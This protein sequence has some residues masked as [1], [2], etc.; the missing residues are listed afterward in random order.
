MG[1]RVST[2]ATWHSITHTH[3]PAVGAPSSQGACRV[4]RPAA[5][6][7]TI[8][9]VKLCSTEPWMLSAHLMRCAKRSSSG[10]FHFKGR[11]LFSYVPTTHKRVVFRFSL[12]HRLIGPLGR[13]HITHVG[14]RSIRETHASTGFLHA[15]L[16][17][18]VQLKAHDACR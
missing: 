5:Q 17:G 15:T 2:W 16:I 12:S 9:K 1:S 4:L 8:P 14:Q 11:A 10:R 7:T 18:L 13:D 3:T 6:R